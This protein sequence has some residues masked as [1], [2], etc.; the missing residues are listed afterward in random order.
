M[1][2]NPVGSAGHGKGGSQATKSGNDVPCPDVFTVLSI[3]KEIAPN[4]E[5]FFHSPEDYVVLYSSPAQ[6]VGKLLP[7]VNNLF[8]G[9]LDFGF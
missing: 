5:G 8:K 9:P 2:C 3:H 6:V 7:I 1:P 4:G